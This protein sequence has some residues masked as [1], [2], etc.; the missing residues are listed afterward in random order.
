MSL[1]NKREEAWFDRSDYVF[2]N[3]EVGLIS[4]IT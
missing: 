3:N 2:V 4:K 1:K